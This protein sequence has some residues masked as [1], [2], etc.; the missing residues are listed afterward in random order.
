METSSSQLAYGTGS[1]ASRGQLAATSVVR[2][3]SMSGQWS[4]LAKKGIAA[5]SN[6]K[7]DPGYGDICRQAVQ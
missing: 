3:G 5:L 2:V 4:P 1:G 7:G 6:G